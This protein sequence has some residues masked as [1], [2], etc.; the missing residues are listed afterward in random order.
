VSG[1]EGYVVL[2]EIAQLVRV[3][4]RTVHRW[5]KDPRF[6]QPVR[7]SRRTLRWD[8]AEVLA[9]LNTTRAESPK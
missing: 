6:P 9:Y 5:R 4:P 3:H 8:L 7:L 1:V 2:S